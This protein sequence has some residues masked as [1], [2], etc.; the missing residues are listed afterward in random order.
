[1]KQVAPIYGKDYGP[2][3]AMFSKSDSNLLSN[4]ISWFGSLQEAAS[5]SASHVLLVVDHRM[6]IEAAAQGI[7]FCRIDERIEDPGLQIVFREPVDLTRK[8]AGQAIDYAISQI[9]RAYDYTGL[10]LGFPLM[11]ASGLSKWISPLRKLPVPFHLPGSRVCSAAVADDYKHT[12]QYR[13]AQ[14]LREWHVSRI[15]PIMLWNSFPFKPFRF[16][17][18]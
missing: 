13:D 12:D 18:H 9:G 6:G 2:G 16:E 3:F 11:I 15:T 1:M 4:G 5:F 7:K 17:A 10:A 8:A 14:L